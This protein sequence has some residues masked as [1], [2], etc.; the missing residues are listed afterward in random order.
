MD[1]IKHNKQGVEILIGLLRRQH[2]SGGRRRNP[3]AYPTL[4]GMPDGSGGAVR[5]V[6]DAGRLDSGGGVAGFRRAA[7]RA[8]RRR[9]S[10]AGLAP[11]VVAH[12]PAGRAGDV[13]EAGGIAGG[14]GRD[15]VAG[16][17]GAH[18]AAGSTTGRI[19]QRGGAIRDAAL[20][21]HS[22]SRRERRRGGSATGAAGAGRSGYRGSGES[23]AG[24]PG[25]FQSAVISG[26]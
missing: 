1:C 9:A 26:I 10:P 15:R 21:R 13:V 6:G 25:G 8:H 22:A 20:G 7:V 3:G 12:F 23:R 19:T 2:R 11:V 17:A 24:Q 16:A 5:G 14:G 18:A 4:R